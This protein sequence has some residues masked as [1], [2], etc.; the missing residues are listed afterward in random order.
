[1]GWL[2]D[3]LNWVRDKAL[4]IGASILSITLGTLFHYLYIGTVYT[5]NA[6]KSK[7]RISDCLIKV[8][9]DLDLF[10][11]DVNLSK[12]RIIQN[13]RGLA[14]DGLTNNYTIYISGKFDEI[15]SLRL[16][17]HELKHVAQYQD[18]GYALF[19]ITYDYQ[20]V[21][22][23]YTS[24]PL[25]KAARKFADD[26]EVKVNDQYDLDCRLVTSPNSPVFKQMIIDEDWTML[27]DL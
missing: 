19:V 22:Y 1:M 5:L 23:G 17:L 26:N 12:V 9:E 18:M 11:S 2:S 16:L 8:M 15:E 25:E 7:K 10:P 21:R 24:A 13:A 27:L 4:D 20:F 3:G 6:F 14:G